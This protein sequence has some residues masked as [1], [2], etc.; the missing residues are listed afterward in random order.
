[1]DLNEVEAK[2]TLSKMKSEQALV[3]EFEKLSP[4]WKQSVQVYVGY[5][6]SFAFL[7]FLFPEITENPVLYLL[8]FLVLGNN[9]HIYQSNQQVHKRIDLLRKMYKK[10]V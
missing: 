7:I 10:G 4:N 5:V 2:L 3:E 9:V 1:M 8:L 6:F